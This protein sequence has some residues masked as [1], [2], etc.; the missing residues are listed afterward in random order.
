MLRG[1]IAIHE[2]FK[3]NDFNEIKSFCDL[4]DIQ[5][6][7]LD[8]DWCVV[9]AKPKRMYKLMKFVRRKYNRKVVNIDL[10]D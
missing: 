10:V 4:N 6:Y 5:I 3:E 7:R 2:T 1:K 9:L 8:M